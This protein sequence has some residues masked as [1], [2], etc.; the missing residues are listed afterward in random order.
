MLNAVEV[1]ELIKKTP[2]TNE[3]IKILKDKWKSNL[4]LINLVIKI[5]L[6]FGD[7]H[8]KDILCFMYFMYI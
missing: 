6:I 5:G 8:L 3:K 7:D 2:V 4:F 1:F